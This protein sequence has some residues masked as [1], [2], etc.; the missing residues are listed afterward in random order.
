MKTQSFQQQVGCWPLTSWQIYRGGS[1][2]G[3]LQEPLILLRLS[4]HRHQV[5]NISAGVQEHFFQPFS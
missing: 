5:G 2:K 4:L 1:R 3:L